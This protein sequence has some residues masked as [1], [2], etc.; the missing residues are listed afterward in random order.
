MATTNL[1]V[2]NIYKQLD[3]EGNKFR[4][5]AEII[6]HEKDTT[7]LSR[8]EPL[9]IVNGWSHPRRTTKGWRL[10]IQW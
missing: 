6:N 9:A 7:T 8:A 4:L 5:I 10:C 3:D 1:I 2:E